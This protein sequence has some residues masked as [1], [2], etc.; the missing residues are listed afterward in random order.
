[1]NPVAMEPFEKAP[2]DML[3]ARPE[4]VR[5]IEINHSQEV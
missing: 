4:N 1:M 2:H 5:D 3:N